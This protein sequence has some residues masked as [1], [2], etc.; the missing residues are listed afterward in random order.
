MKRILTISLWV[1]IM[2]AMPIH[3]AQSYVCDFENEADRNRWVLNPVATSDIYA[4]LTNKWYMG[5]LGNNGKNGQYGLYISDDGGKTA[6]YTNNGCWTVAYDI[7]TLDH[8]ATAA[9]Y[10]IS[11][12]YM[13]MGNV[14]SDFDGIYLLWIPMLDP[15]KGD[16]IKVM[17]IA[18][19][20]NK[21]PPTYE[22][23]II[24]LQPKAMIDYV[25][26]TST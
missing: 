7:I 10:T 14:A 13:G 26:A 11:F 22:N 23:Y 19:S 16:S 3:A 12:D 5:A 25:N 18:T 9:D 21:V 1:L 17:S 24:Q 6:H 15:D 2:M 20:A 8:L 4:N